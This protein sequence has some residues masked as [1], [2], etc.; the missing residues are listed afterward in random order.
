MYTIAYHRKLYFDKMKEES[1]GNRNKI[2]DRSRIVVLPAISI[3]VAKKIIIG[4]I[5][6]AA[7]HKTN[8]RSAIT[9]D[10]ATLVVG[11][12][13]VQLHMLPSCHRSFIHKERTAALVCRIQL[14]LDLEQI[15]T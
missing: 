4:V 9:I 8:G 11:V 7:L 5:V 15:Q 10:G 12:I 6:D 14:H 1:L 13:V 2:G 3:W